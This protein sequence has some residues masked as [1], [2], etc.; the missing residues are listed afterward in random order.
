MRD[1]GER[2]REKNKDIVQMFLV[3]PRRVTLP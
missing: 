3:V 1:E 2:E